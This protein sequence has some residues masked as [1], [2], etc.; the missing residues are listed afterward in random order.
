MS[1]NEL[2]ALAY[3]IFANINKLQKDLTLINQVIEKKSKGEKI[4]HKDLDKKKQAK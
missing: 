1:V 2:K 3:D 4:T